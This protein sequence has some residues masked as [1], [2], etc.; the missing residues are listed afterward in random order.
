MTS[1]NSCERWIW[2]ELIGFDNTQPDFGVAEYFAR[3]G[4]IP[5][6]VTFLI[7]SP[8]IVHHHEGIENE[9]ILPPDCCSYCGHERNSER[10]RQEW[11]NHQLRALV[12]E[13]QSRGIAVFLATFTFYLQ[14][15]FHHEWVGDFPELW[16]TRRNG[17]PIYALMPL[18]RFSDGAFY[19]DFFIPKMARVLSDYGFDGWHAA[20]GWGPPRLPVNETDYSDDMFAQFIEAQ[21]I[22]VP[23]DIKVLCNDDLE[24]FARRSDWVWSTQRKAWI[25][26]YTER[27]AAFHKKQADALKAAGKRVVIN[28]A[29]TR[30]PFEAIYRYGV[31]YRKIIAAGVEGI[32][33][34]SA[35]CASDLEAEDGFRLENYTAAL[36]LIRAAVPDA[37]LLFLHGV[38]DTNEQW[39]VIHHAPT[40]LEKEIF[41]LSSVFLQTGKTLR[42]S[43]DGF[44]IC[45]GDG[46]TTQEWQWL[47]KRWD[48][49]YDEIP[50]ELLGATLLWSDAAFNNELDDFIVHRSPT[51]H[52][53][54]YRLMEQNAP[55]RAAVRIENLPNASGP[56]LVLNSHL[57]PD[58]ERVQVLSYANGPIIF[59]ERRER[60]YRCFVHGDETGEVLAP[61]HDE[62]YSRS[63]DIEPTTFL[64]D[65][66]MQVL[67]DEFLAECAALIH[68]ATGGP[69]LREGA[70]NVSLQTMRMENGDLKIL[71][72]NS[73]ARY[74]RPLLDVGQ[75]IGDIEI[76]TEFP[77]TKISTD[78]PQFFIKIPLRGATMLRI[79][80]EYSGKEN[81]S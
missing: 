73:G 51:T 50:A 22:E 26:F 59:L 3:A 19:E 21:N 41:S 15:Q 40:I 66:P 11:T 71:L 27:W 28:S 46:I 24:A 16:E 74:A 55:V 54:L 4:F 64:A 33:T 72:K 42:R 44:V 18:K 13:L 20:D 35:A 60:D 31:D 34:E 38:K 6:A 78:D 58:A 17:E 70:E 67:S 76:M 81:R 75:N 5:Q 79:T 12:K 23:S 53:L 62:E 57:L 47:Q 69:Q 10:E 32:I 29:W 1:K 14:H 43:A 7:T 61:R 77:C 63:A 48:I 8:D 68:A 56:L 30:D 39:D 45:L 37:R 52:R 65:T 25:H 9:I 49:V 36:L 80:P 2:I